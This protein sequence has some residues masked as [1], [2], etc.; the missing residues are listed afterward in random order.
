VLLRNGHA[1][2]TRRAMKRLTVIFGTN[3]GV[4]L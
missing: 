4:D 3:V 2:Y 1:C